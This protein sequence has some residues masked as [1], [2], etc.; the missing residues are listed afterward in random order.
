MKHL[1]L[2]RVNPA[3]RTAFGGAFINRGSAATWNPKK[4][5]GLIALAWLIGAIVRAGRLIRKEWALA[6]TLAAQFDSDRTAEARLLLFLLAS[7]GVVA[8]LILIVRH[9]A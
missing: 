6:T 4:T 9:F 2:V 7:L 1:I 5:L 3:S 8:L